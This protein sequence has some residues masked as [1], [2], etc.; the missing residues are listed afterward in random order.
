LSLAIGALQ[1]MLDRGELK[2]WFSSTE[3]WISATIAGLCF[4]LFVVHTVTATDRSFLNRDLLKDGNFVAGT[5]MMFFIG[6][7]LNGTLAL[8]PT[9]LQELMNYPVLTTGLVT[10]PRGIGTMIAMFLV[11]HLIG[12]VNTRLIILTGLGLTAVSLWQMTGFSLQMGMGPVISTGVLQGF[13]LGFVFTPLST[14]TFSTLPRQILTQGT[15][16]FSLTRNIGGSCGIAVVE[17]LLAENTQIVHSRLVEH[18]R[19]D[20]PL[21][22]APYLMPPFSLTIPS[23]VAALN[24]EA[25]RQA[26]M[27]A[28]IDDFKLMMMI[29]VAGLPLLLLLRKPRPAPTA[30]A[31]AE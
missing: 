2:D 22:Q 20:N 12:R 16:I 18:L 10:A 14:V 30:T 26:A 4:Y 6:I 9:M 21:A 31:A 28:Y 23:G 25:T 17:A 1:L 29:V 19:P 11:V 3:I 5:V 27:V 7:I 24:A 15:A 8:V 13:G